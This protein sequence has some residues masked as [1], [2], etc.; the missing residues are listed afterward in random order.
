MTTFDAIVI[1]SGAG[2]SPVA[3]RLCA[4]GM[5][6]LLIER[7]KRYSKKDFDR[8]EIEWSRR[9][10]FQPSVNTNPH[11]RRGDEGAKAQ[12]TTDGWIASVY[13]GGTIH[14]SGFFLPFHE[15]DSKQKTRLDAQGEK[16]HSALD[17]AVPYEEIARYYPTVVS[18]M[19]VT[20]LED[21]KM[22]ALG[23]HPVAQRCDEVGKKLGVPVR[24]T[25]RAIVSENRPDEDRT[26]CAYRLACA[27]Y[28][29]PNDARGSMLVTY[30]RRAEKSGNLTVWAQAQALRLEKDGKRV[31][32]VVVHRLD[33]GTEEKVSAGIVVVA[34]SAIESA[35]LLLLSDINPGKQVGKN[36]WFSIYVDVNGWLDA[37]KHPDVLVGSPFIHRTFFEGGKLTDGVLKEQQLDRAGALDVLWQHDNPIHR[38]ERV[39]TEG[40]LLWGASLKD[41]MV[42]HFTQGRTV[43]CEG[44]GEFTPHPGCYTDLD[45]DVKDHL[46]RPVARMTI[47]HHAR[48]QRVAKAL[49]FEGERLLRE[50]QCDNVRTRVSLGETLIL[51]GG[52]CRFSNSEQDGVTTPNGNVHGFDNLYVTDGGTLPSSGTAPSTMTI[53]ANA[54]R[55]AEKIKVA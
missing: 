12:P 29:C 5:K 18:E 11:T 17:W 32:G 31:T 44:F 49:S 53:V 38:A 26:A 47:W 13:G 55:I 25:P 14:M 8:D 39:A 54:L 21:S 30:L 24:R 50:L 37:K 43:L 10:K 7:G 19:G 2:G 46:G 23:E 1:G 34:G 48:D 15:E 4:R 22:A 40:K 35:R 41:A 36:L 45:P 16:A 51:Q 27:S 52:T 20:G 42:K 33:T 6:V 3:Q 28:G 9:D